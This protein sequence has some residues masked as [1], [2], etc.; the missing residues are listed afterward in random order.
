MTGPVYS[1][2]GFVAMNFF[3]LSAFSLAQLV[4]L[5]LSGKSLKSLTIIRSPSLT[6]STRVH[7][8]TGLS[9]TYVGETATAVGG[10]EQDRLSATAATGGDNE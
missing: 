10:P 2:S 5:T 6:H 4:S 8:P 1:S 9:T 3:I 7:S